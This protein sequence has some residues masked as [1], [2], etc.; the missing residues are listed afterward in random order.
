MASV[1]R[2]KRPH[3][4]PAIPQVLASSSS[5]HLPV[6][7]SIRE[8][9][10]YSQIVSASITSVRHM[11]TSTYQSF[12]KMIIPKVQSFRAPP[13]KMLLHQVMHITSFTLTEGFLK[14]NTKTTLLNRWKFYC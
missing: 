2:R 11:R 9:P 10:K 3:C 8:N 1:K 13:A 7:E 6:V 5:S 4:H 14:Q 12:A